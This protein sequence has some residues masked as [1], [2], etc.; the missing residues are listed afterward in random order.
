VL[1]A[2][3]TAMGQVLLLAAYPILTRVYT[4]HDFGI[5][6]VFTSLLG[7]PMTVCSWRY[8]CAIPIAKKD[9]DAADLFTL[10]LGILVV[11]SLL[12]ALALAL[13]AEYVV[14]WT[15]APDLRPFLWILP[16]SVVGGGLFQILS[17]WAMREQAF[18]AIA[19]GKLM[20]SVG[21]AFVQIGGSLLG[22]AVGLMIGDAMGR[23]ASAG[24]F[25]G[26][27]KS[28]RQATGQRMN[29]ERL[30]SVALSYGRISTFSSLSTFVDNVGQRFPFLLVSAYYGTD[31]LG[32]FSLAQQITLVLAVLVG[33]SVSQVYT[34][35]FSALMKRSPEACY[36][37]FLS[38]TKKLFLLGLVPMGAIAIIGPTVFALV[39]GAEWQ[40]AGTYAV[41]LAPMALASLVVLPLGYT[42]YALDRQDLQLLWSVAQLVLACAAI[43]SAHLLDWPP[44]AAVVLFSVAQTLV[45]ILY[46]LI[47]L[48]VLRT[49]HKQAQGNLT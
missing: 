19:R 11:A 38:T 24:G 31:V 9:A 28:M 43:V 49:Y 23:L 7:L 13:G 17:Y 41:V 5:Y 16:L 22:G 8:E 35:E 27:A 32:L 14:A 6:V 44:F 48:Y 15:E 12:I 37:F 25:T 29:V 21:Q 40:A 18:S 26:C 10:A 33:K 46:Y 34:S 39:F 36:R 1:L 47:T 30:R 4:P 45:Y 2:G 3:A 42:L 20:Q